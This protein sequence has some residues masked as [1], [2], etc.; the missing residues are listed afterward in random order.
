MHDHVDMIEQVAVHFDRKLQNMAC[1]AT[2][3]L[4]DIMETLHILCMVCNG[5]ES[6]EQAAAHVADAASCSYL[7]ATL[8]CEWLTKQT[9]WCFCWSKSTA[10]CSCKPGTLPFNSRQFLQP[11][12]PTCICTVKIYRC[13]HTITFPCAPVTYCLA[14][15][16]LFLQCRTCQARLL[17]TA[18]ADIDGLRSM[19]KP[20]DNKPSAI[21]C[22]NHYFTLCW[23]E[24]RLHC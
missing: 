2:V 6:T 1:L 8:H 5:S 19:S 17:V 12:A 22:S 20:L 23:P 9:I 21:E 11:L 13:A 15:K 4:A 10:L 16:V 24:N 14:A 3:E 18:E 7:K